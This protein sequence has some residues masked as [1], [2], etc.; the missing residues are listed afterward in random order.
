MKKRG[1]QEE[2]YYKGDDVDGAG[3]REV[4]TDE[5][6]RYGQQQRGSPHYGVGL[7]AR[8]C[9]PC[10]PRLGARRTQRSEQAKETNISLK[11]SSNNYQGCSRGL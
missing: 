4:E 11:G 10:C 9:A 8:G 3:G 6:L 5:D 2:V 7:S 1:E